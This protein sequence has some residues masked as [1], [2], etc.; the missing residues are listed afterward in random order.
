M[1]YI[2]ILILYIQQNIFMHYSFIPFHYEDLQ[3]FL[4]MVFPSQLDIM[5]GSY[6]SEVCLYQTHM[7]IL[8]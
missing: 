5:S 8:Y 2:A 3:R 4:N 7:I 1:T 6:G